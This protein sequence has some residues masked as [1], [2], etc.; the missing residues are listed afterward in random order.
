MPEPTV[1]VR[2]CET[3]LNDEAHAIAA[4]TGGSAA[5]GD[6]RLLPD[7][8]WHSIHCRFNHAYRSTRAFND[9]RGIK[10]TA[11]FELDLEPSTQQIT[12]RPAACIDAFKA[13]PNMSMLQI[14]L[15]TVSVDG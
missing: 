4:N 13:D 12:Y 14:Q 1:S 15:V 9:T 11:N 7:L 2:E 8:G 10:T 6:W 5:L 3:N